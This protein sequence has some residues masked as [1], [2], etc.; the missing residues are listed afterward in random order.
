MEWA[1]N[2]VVAVD[3]DGQHGEDGCRYDKSGEASAD[4][5]Q[6]PQCCHL[7]VQYLYQQDGHDDEECHEIR[8]HQA[9]HEPARSNGRT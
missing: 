9:K 8:E 4:L 7:V 1:Q 6:P 2:G 3:G 5:P